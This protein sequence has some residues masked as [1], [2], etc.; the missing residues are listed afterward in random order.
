MPF[1]RGL[2]NLFRSLA[3]L[4]VFDLGKVGIR[5][6]P[7]ALKNMK[8][9]RHL[10]LSHNPITELLTSVASLCSLETLDLTGCSSLKE[11]PQK[12]NQMSSLRYL[13]LGGTHKIRYLPEGI[14]G[15]HYTERIE[16]VFENLQ[17]CKTLAKLAVEHYD[18]KKFPSWMTY[19]WLSNLVE[20]RLIQCVNC[21]LL[22]LFG[23]TWKESIR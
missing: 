13:E 9:L 16:P 18:G 12:I 5:A 3:S 1:S 23:A 7:K 17:P 8:H 14:G 10:I 22:P 20:V 2:S 4:T 11:L 21:E 19:P 6:L 15:T